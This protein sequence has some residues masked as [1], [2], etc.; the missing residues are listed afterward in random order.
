MSCELINSKCTKFQT[1][2]RTQCE[3]LISIRPILVSIRLRCEF[4]QQITLCTQ[5]TASGTGT[6]CES[7]GRRHSAG[8]FIPGAVVLVKFRQRISGYAELCVLQP[9]RRGTATGTGE[10]GDS[11]RRVA[12]SVVSSRCAQVRNPKIFRSGD[13]FRTYGGRPTTGRP[14]TARVRPSN[15]QRR[16]FEFSSVQPSAE[17]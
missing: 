1:Y 15:L 17:F 3:I 4:V 11:F 10:P 8:A 9:A 16:P 12:L 6:R 2:S 13:I 5:G 7:S 14:Y